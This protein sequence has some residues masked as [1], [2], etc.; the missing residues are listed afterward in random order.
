VWSER[1]VLAVDRTGFVFLYKHLKTYVSAVAKSELSRAV[2]QNQKSDRISII[3]RVWR[4]NNAV[5]G[6]ENK[7]R[8]YIFV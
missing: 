2:V 8:K 5:F 3:D 4:R 7:R 1:G 6:G